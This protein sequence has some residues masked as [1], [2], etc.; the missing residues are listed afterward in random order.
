MVEA[1]GAFVIIIGAISVIALIGKILG[2]V[3]PE[4]LQIRFW[5][6][7]GLDTENLPPYERD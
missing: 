4:T 2:A 5:K 3:L 6:A 1:Y 7:L